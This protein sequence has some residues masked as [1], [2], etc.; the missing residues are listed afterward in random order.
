MG[1]FN[2]WAAP[3][4]IAAA[5]VL[6]SATYIVVRWRRAPAALR[7]IAGVAI[8]C[9]VAGFLLGVWAFHYGPNRAGAT[10]SRAEPEVSP[11]LVPHA[12]SSTSVPVVIHP[13]RSTQTAIYV[14]SR[15]R[16]TTYALGGNG[17]VAPLTII[18]GP[19]LGFHKLRR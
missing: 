13:T 11:T 12:E 8:V 14:A 2:P 5:L 17:N 1:G 10:G 7:A 4:L 19:R 9:L 15:D 3:A 18:S 16:V 6:G